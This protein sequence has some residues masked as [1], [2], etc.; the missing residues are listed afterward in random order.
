MGL[1]LFDRLSNL[2]SGLG[3]AKDKITQATF[4]LVELN[5]L[6][7]LNAYRGDWIARKVVD[8][9]PFDMVR[10]W[11]DWQADGDH[12][13]K[14]EAS[15]AALRV[16]GKVAK[17]MKLGR[18]FG[19]GALIMGVEQGTNADPLDVERVGLGSLKY[20]LRRAQVLHDQQCA[21]RGRRYPPLTGDPLLRR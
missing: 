16:R 12:I 6:E 19:G 21:G 14:L 15:E 1:A 11:R 13:E 7:L 2:V 9:P 8:V 4:G 18:L 20:L 10:E 5:Q 3:T 17:A